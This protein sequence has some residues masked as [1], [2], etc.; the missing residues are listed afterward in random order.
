MDVPG[1]S[2]EAL[3]AS[4]AK[5]LSSVVSRDG[6]LEKFR[7]LLADKARVL[8]SQAYSEYI[9]QLH[10]AAMSLAASGDVS[11][12]VGGLLIA[13]CLLDV[14]D[15]QHMERRVNFAGKVKQILENNAAANYHVRVMTTAAEALGHLSRLGSTTEME[16]LKDYYLV[17]ALTWL[18]DK[19]NQVRRYA[20]VLI[21]HQLAEN[22]ASLF[23]ERRVDFFTSIWE[24]VVDEQGH[25]REAASRAL[26][27]AIFVVSERGSS[28]Q[29]FY[30]SILD[31]IKTSLR[32]DS[33]A[34]IHGALLALKTILALPFNLMADPNEL[35]RPKTGIACVVR[36]HVDHARRDI[37][38][39]VVEVL[40][41][42]LCFP[43]SEYYFDTRFVVDIME[44][45]IHVCQKPVTKD[46]LH[47][48][49]F[50]ALGAISQVIGMYAKKVAGLMEDVM[51]SIE[52]ALGVPEA[53]DEALRCLGEIFKNAEGASAKFITRFLDLILGS[54]LSPVLIDTLRLIVES[55]A[56][57]R[58]QV[59]QC[60][61]GLLNAFLR[62]YT[63]SDRGP[64]PSG[65]LDLSHI[66][67]FVHG[68]SD[69]N[70]VLPRKGWFF[71]RSPS[72]RT[73]QGDEPSTAEVELA[74]KTL[75][76]FDF[77]SGI[78][79]PGPTIKT[80]L[81][82][83]QDCALPCLDDLNPSVRGT[84]AECT[85]AVLD[86]A[87]SEGAFS[88]SL[89]ED[90][91]PDLQ[92]Q[93]SFALARR[94]RG[95]PMTRRER[96]NGARTPSKIPRGRSYEA[97]DTTRDYLQGSSLRTSR[98]S[99]PF[100]DYGNDF[101]AGSSGSL[102]KA[103]SATEFEQANPRLRE[104][105]S[106]S[107]GVAEH[108]VIEQDNETDGS[109]DSDDERKDAGATDA[110]L[111]SQ[112]S[113]MRRADNRIS[114]LFRKGGEEDSSPRS[115]PI[116]RPTS[117]EARHTPSPSPANRRQTGLRRTSN[118]VAE[119]G[120]HLGPLSQS[121]NCS[122]YDYTT[123]VIK[124]VRRLLMLATADEHVDIRRRV[125]QSLTRI[126]SLD[127][128]IIY[129][130]NVHNLFSALQDES[131][132]VRDAAIQIVGRLGAS[133][134]HFVMPKVRQLIFELVRGV[135]YSGDARVKSEAVSLV[136][137]LATGVGRGMSSYVS[138]IL[139]P[140]ME[141]L[142][143]HKARSTETASIIIQGGRQQIHSQASEVLSSLLHAIGALSVINPEAMRPVQSRVMIR[144]TGCLQDVGSP[145]RQL[146]STKVLGQIVSSTGT[147][148]RPYIEHRGMLP[149]LLMI[150]Q[151]SDPE[152]M[153]LR[154]ETLRTIGLIGALDP[155]T[156]RMVTKGSPD[157]SKEVS[158]RPGAISSSTAFSSLQIPL[159][160]GH[161]G[162]S[163]HNGLLR[164][165]RQAAQAGMGAFSVFDKAGQL[166]SL[167]HAP[168]EV[169]VID[170]Y[171]RHARN[172]W[173]MGI[174]DEEEGGSA[175]GSGTMDKLGLGFE[176]EDIGTTF[177]AKELLSLGDYY[178]SQAIGALI[179]MLEDPALALHH[180]DALKVALT[181]IRCL[182][183]GKEGLISSM[184]RGFRMA[185][186]QRDT[187][188]PQQRELLTNFHELLLVAGPHGAKHLEHIIE[189]VRYF[190]RSDSPR[191]R[192]DGGWAYAQEILDILFTVAY[193]TEKEHQYPLSNWLLPR[194]LEWV[195]AGPDDTRRLHVLP[196]LRIVAVL[197]DGMG[198]LKRLVVP[199]LIDV[200]E[201]PD[202]HART[203]MR[204][205]QV[206]VH[207]TACPRGGHEDDSVFQEYATQIIQILL[208]ILAHAEVQQDPAE[209]GRRAARSQPASPVGAFA[210]PGSPANR[211]R[212]ISTNALWPNAF[213]DVVLLSL[214][215]M[216]C[217]LGER[218]LQFMV[219]C[220]R[221]ISSQCTGIPSYRVLERKLVDLLHNRLSR[222]E[223]EICEDNFLKAKPRPLQSAQH[224]SG[225][226]NMRAVAAAFETS[227]RSVE[228][229]WLEWMRRVSIELLRQSPSPVLFSCSALA[230]IYQPLAMELFNASFIC[231]WE[232]LRPQGTAV[233]EFNE[234]IVTRILKSIEIALQSERLPPDVMQHLLNLVEFMELEDKALP[235]NF[236]LLGERASAGHAYAKCLHYKEMEFSRTP[237]PSCAEALIWVNSQLGL[238]D[239]AAGI[240][241][242]T[243]T[244]TETFET[245][246]FEGRP[247]W[248][249]KLEKW[250]EALHAYE[251]L[252]NKLDVTEVGFS[253]AC[254]AAAAAS[255]IRGGGGITQLS[256]AA[257]YDQQIAG[258]SPLFKDHSKS[259][260][261]GVSSTFTK[262]SSQTSA[263]SL[264]SFARSSRDSDFSIAASPPPPIGT[265]GI[266]GISGTSGASGA[267]ED[268]RDLPP[269]LTIGVTS[270]TLSADFKREYQLEYRLES[271]RVKPLIG[272]LESEKHSSFGTTISRTNS[273]KEVVEYLHVQKAR[274]IM[275]YSAEIG[276]LRC[277][278]AQ[279]EYINLYRG[280]MKIFERLTQ[281]PDAAM[282][283]T[284]PQHW[285][286][287]MCEVEM[288]GAKASVILQ[289]WH[290]MEV[291]LKKG[292][293]VGRELEAAPGIY[294]SMLA[295][296]RNRFDEALDRVT[297]ARRGMAAACG[298]L[299]GESY[300]RAY[301]CLV[302]A[303]QL[304]EL[305]EIIG[306]KR[307]LI[308]ISESTATDPQ[309]LLENAG[310]VEPPVEIPLDPSGDD[311]TIRLDEVAR[312][313]DMINEIK[314][315]AQ[316]MDYEDRHSKQES[317]FYEVDRE[318]R[319]LRKKWNI[320]L[321]WVA[322]DVTVWK[323]LLSLRTL[324]ISPK[325]DLNTWLELASLC[326]RNGELTLCANVL[327]LLGAPLDNGRED[328]P[329]HPKVLLALFQL[330]RAKGNVGLSLKLAKLFTTALEDVLGE[331]A[332]GK[333]F[334]PEKP[335]TL[336]PIEESS[337]A[338][339]STTK[340]ST[341]SQ[342]RWTPAKLDDVITP[343]YLRRSCVT[344]FRGEQTKQAPSVANR[345]VVSVKQLVA[346]AH[347]LIA[348]WELLESENAKDHQDVGRIQ[349]IMNDLQRATELTPTSC[350]AWHQWARVNH[351]MVDVMKGGGDRSKSRREPAPQF[352]TRTPRYA[353]TGAKD[354]D[355]GDDGEAA[356][357]VVQAIRGY[358]RS[359]SF[360]SF[361]GDSDHSLGA[362]R[363]TGKSLNQSKQEPVNAADRLQDTL[364][365]LTLW[366]NNTHVPAVH[367]EVELGINQ[368][369]VH[370]WLDV[371]PQII[372]RLDDRDGKAI[373]LMIKLLTI[374]GRA[375]PQALIFPITVA[376]KTTSAPR[377]EAALRIL[378]TMREH[379]PELVE[380]SNMVSVNIIRVAITWHEMWHEG[381]EMASR[382]YF[383]EN[384]VD[385]ML[386]GLLQLHESAMENHPSR[387]R[388]LSDR[389][390]L[391][392]DIDALH[393]RQSG[394][395]TVRSESFQHSFG[396]ELQEALEWLLRFRC[397]REAEDLNQAWRIY[398]QVFQRISKQLTRLKT[399]E[400]Q[401]VAPALLRATNLRLAVLG[402]YTSSTT[403]PNVVRIAGFGSR[404]SVI[405]SKQRPRKISIYGSNGKTYTFLLKGHEDLRQDERVMQLFGLMNALLASTPTTN[406][407]NLRIRRYAVLPLSN[408]SGLIGWVPNSDTIQK[409]VSAYREARMIPPLLEKKMMKAIPD[410]DKLPLI[411]KLEV[412]Q[413]VLACTQGQDLCKM[414]WLQS[415]NSEVWL[416]R[417]TTYTRSL[418]VM[419]IAGYILGLG[420]R[421]LNN[422]MIE[423]HTGRVVHI[424]FGD[425]FEVASTRSKYPEK[426]P[427]RLTRMLVNAMEVSGIEGT[428]RSTCEKVMIVLRES[429][430][431][432]MALLEAFIHDPL[433]SWRL[434]AEQQAAM[435]ERER[436]SSLSQTAQTSRERSVS[437]A[438]AVAASGV[439]L[440]DHELESP[441]GPSL[442]TYPLETGVQT[443][444]V[445]EGQNKRALEVISR[446]EDKLRGRDFM[447]L[448]AAL[449]GLHPDG[450]FQPAQI[451]V[452]GF[453]QTRENPDNAPS[454]LQAKEQVARLIQE[455]RSE[456]NLCQAFI[457]WAPYW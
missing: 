405:T 87:M 207:I 115:R 212:A 423:Q 332:S 392:A 265:R 42:L 61:L 83:V 113:A 196:V 296:H 19:R 270:R 162:G 166:N 141:E 156:L 223:P 106:V 326:R 89:L 149:A 418:A 142:V 181:I 98:S 387:R 17:P 154:L 1:A 315:L 411:H 180:A 152:S 420:D 204:A 226:K 386:G 232:Y 455:A 127:A 54:G 337:E 110:G 208:R 128:L 97:K 345:R 12:R 247:G 71:R 175:T 163:L 184:M 277:Y 446:I 191:N 99:D 159:H 407:A 376:S 194:L 362:S 224:P 238:P 425:C 428:Y 390:D 211:V 258:M 372:A 396:R 7:A 419:S 53:V 441:E 199:R 52:K 58:P 343:D 281:K 300:A 103:N 150:L 195:R 453:R 183:V 160:G 439:R 378:E 260:S 457:G 41:K 187:R 309:A 299:L 172:M 285:N 73:Y 377:R 255:N 329:P 342:A 398:Y 205:L 233:N 452:A 28:V 48:E 66:E 57:S 193:Y 74:F 414:L 289:Q 327:K 391:D 442:P 401:H 243:E 151:R 153:D 366:F 171:G 129:P 256:G 81:L 379:S 2:A 120:G 450:R 182:E 31:R 303:Q 322:E 316:R 37:R 375:H 114:T 93:Q 68:S 413:G 125:L 47:K 65:L 161:L 157:S 21:L 404:V 242:A 346:H 5:Q 352:R 348:E 209:R 155:L 388:W 146:A 406:Q 331:V 91:E 421:H 297:A 210:P 225:Q 384:N 94:L 167:V 64:N 86:L 284:F 239:A 50:R 85:I 336:H 389:K 4:L 228:G 427:F 286:S 236:H 276:R 454:P 44:R 16:F 250:D 140:F 353:T 148:V 234:Y 22:T 241:K 138:S 251:E 230:R 417:R 192:S 269:S 227:G 374:V 177:A 249:E 333:T 291:F 338:A 380:E 92:L 381:I 173:N 165:M 288:L 240:L 60:L 435:A 272:E 203:R 360:G 10:D 185:F 69:G 116:V 30:Q 139:R 314:L 259:S 319:T 45:I 444:E 197:K 298:S 456:E 46:S 40:P 8:H 78:T 383:H 34:D 268:S 344:L 397:T 385:A 367:D 415:Q 15:I 328:D 432:L 90:G 354:S 164:S 449:R 9:S 29:N 426:V 133:H 25:I 188:S 178:N 109:S 80:M 330:M 77:L 424:D 6:A 123:V 200:V 264:S 82:L 409:L 253:L 369:S 222:Q 100:V 382:L 237:S 220:Q 174:S 43:P 254:Q 266:S 358:F 56:P 282:V 416:D 131:F 18:R 317:V 321:S 111:P 235:L 38:A 323:S 104:L 102:L 143:R 88:S 313:S 365:L 252:I 436:A 76:T 176:E 290:S 280:A 429:R 357:Y 70:P 24:C 214:T 275:R 301:R 274:E 105:R 431:S 341:T 278:E 434:L 433:I 135:Q 335:R 136:G 62:S 325:Q 27:A 201:H 261:L 35:Y 283:L 170:P 438:E 206:L 355:A 399:V 186:K 49:G 231:F 33:P 310:F 440:H 294:E 304:A 67:S 422:I 447:D 218:F 132:H 262:T 26:G 39:V 279:G 292:H 229:D 394:A 448:D 145:M 118:A 403:E 144:I 79:K 287:W 137:T 95:S 339:A 430:A 410:Y 202:K 312:T 107:T 198:D 308:Q 147:V 306:L 216:I 347:V 14:A 364:R 36:S 190:W 393:Q 318:L 349:S 368:I 361:Y 351:L 334:A 451:L 443:V 112:S 75:G 324:V 340:E 124:A 244:Q 363:T 221:Q 263:T 23:Y 130:E 408:N 179:G 402:T 246:T 373:A 271:L 213:Y 370:T 59:Q 122:A 121:D 412:F 108:P 445:R 134:P 320:R 96:S 248:F 55:Q 51:S 215:C 295:L 32:S 3:V 400:L 219:P 350:R 356:E 126:R 189:I 217:R 84:A 311:R 20:A 302:G 267:S 395:N 371:I 437:V 245:Q 305:E 307:K 117:P 257:E 119:T 63:G 168:T 72:E 293:I 359:L 169:V 13:D 101:G 273:S 158:W 11:Q